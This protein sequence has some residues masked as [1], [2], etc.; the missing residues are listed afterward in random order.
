MAPR[1][2]P[3]KTLQVNVWAVSDTNDTFDEECVVSVGMSCVAVWMGVVRL[4]G[5]GMAPGCGANV[6]HGNGVISFIWLCVG[7]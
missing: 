4:W 7:H 3:S 1:K 2:L 6:C 5:G